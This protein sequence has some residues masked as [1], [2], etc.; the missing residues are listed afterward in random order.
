MK[1]TITGQDGFIGFHLYNSIKYKYPKID[2]I[3]FRKDYFKDSTKID[4]IFKKTDIIIHLAGINR[5]DDEKYLFDQ[6]ILLGQKIIDSLIRVNF[7]GKLIFASSIQEND[8]TLYGKAKKLSREMFFKESVKRGYKFIALIMPNVFG[9]FCKPNYN[10]FI[11]TFCQNLIKGEKNNIIDD[12]GVPLIYVDNLIQKIISSFKTSVSDNIII[13]EDLIIEVS[14]VKTILEYFNNNYFQNGTIPYLD[15]NFKKNLFL[16]YLSYIPLGNYFPREINNLNDS[17]G[18]FSEV[19]RSN[20]SG[21]YSYS[22]TKPNKK[23]GDHF[24]TR[25]IERFIVIA[26]NA[27]VELRMVGSSKKHIFKLNGLS[28][29]YIDMPIWFTHNITNTGNTPLITLFWINEFFK[30]SD[31]DTYSEKV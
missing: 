3:D 13:K 17:R 1:V 20:V 15:S 31:P 18:S 22:I 9:P 6:N 19:I 29:S 23:R 26:G 24:H 4:R 14:K 12:K 27:N 30:E 16:T 8:E 2:L 25:K 7:K 11:S 5:H 21:Q 10:S 28:P